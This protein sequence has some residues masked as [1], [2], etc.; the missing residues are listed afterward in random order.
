MSAT[1]KAPA[2]APTKEHPESESESGQRQATSPLW[3]RAPIRH[4]VMDATRS[5]RSRT[6]ARRVLMDVTPR[7]REAMVVTGATSGRC[8][9]ADPADPYDHGDASGSAL[10]STPQRVRADDLSRPFLSTMTKAIR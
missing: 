10:G 3:S 8:G 5:A 1:P 9:R 6:D 4:L 7:T 2:A